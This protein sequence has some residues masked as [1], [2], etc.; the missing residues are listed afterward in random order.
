M[1]DWA[2]VRIFLSVHRE[3][4]FTAAARALRL[5]QTTVGRRIAALESALGARLLRRGRDGLTLTAAGVEA[6]ARAEQMEEAA[7]SLGRA[8]EQRDEQPEGK[9][10]LTTLESLA[11]W[12]LAPRLPRLQ[13]RHP[14]LSL[15]LHV[16]HRA[17]SLTRREADLALRLTRPEQPGLVS[18]KVASLAWGL[19]GERRWLSKQ[20]TPGPA[21]EGLAAIGF[22]E[23]L[24]ALPEARWLAATAA[25]ITLRTSSLPAMREA[26][27]AG[28]G[29]A[30]LP[31]WL[32]DQDPRLSRALDLP[33]RR[34]LWLVVH[35]ELRTAARVRA[36]ADFVAAEAR[37]A[38]PANAPG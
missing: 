34:D 15:E 5:D 13:Q 36:V 11:T 37:A 25:Q 27:A 28:A 7:Q 9:V 10:R 38:F 16:G 2:D 14:K 20:P 12:F 8:V 24:S 23:E 19:Y 1:F 35:A 33:V 31:R 18:R 26:C 21:L 30:V 22:D 32:G 17:L 6:L 29:L 4:S 3:G